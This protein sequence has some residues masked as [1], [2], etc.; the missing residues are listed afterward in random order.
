MDDK[1]HIWLVH[2]H[3]KRHSRAHDQPVLEQ[4]PPLP[5]AAHIGVQPRM[6]SERR[7]ALAFKRLGQLLGCLARCCIDNSRIAFMRAHQRDHA[8]GPAPA[9]GLGGEYQ[10]RAVKTRYMDRRTLQPEL[11]QNILACPLIRRRR[12][13]KPRYAGKHLPQAAKRPIIGP[14]IM[15]P[16]AH[17]VRFIDR[18]QRHFQAR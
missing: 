11:R 12:H 9:F 6:I 15:P 10:I 8:V 1:A 5:F 13:R 2:A 3:A 16:L 18:N 14:E 7:D 4:E 17:T